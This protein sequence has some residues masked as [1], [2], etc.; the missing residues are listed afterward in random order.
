MKFQVF[1]NHP[2]G[3]SLS[4]L[5]GLSDLPQVDVSCIRLLSPS[6]SKINPYSKLL[7]GL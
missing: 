2:G 4:Q 5:L 3:E 6:P 7:W 1:F